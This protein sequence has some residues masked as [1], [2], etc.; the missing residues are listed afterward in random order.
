MLFLGNVYRDSFY[1]SVPADIVVPDKVIEGFVG[2]WLLSSLLAVSCVTV[3]FCA[4]MQIVQDKVTGAIGD[5]SVTPYK[6]SYLALS[7]YLATAA[8]TAAICY[9]A[10]GAGF[11]YLACVGWYI[12]A[13]DALF[14]VLDVFLLS[15]FGTA[16]SS[17][18]CF[19]IKTQGG[20]TA[21]SVVVS[22][23]YGF[24]SGAYM[25]ISQFANGI[26]IFVSLLPGTYG[27]GLFRNHFMGGV[28]AE[29][30][31]YFPPEV[32]DGIRTSFDCNM[33]FFGHKVEVGTMFLILGVTV[34]V[35]IGVYVLL[36]FLKKRAKN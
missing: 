4:N 27:T 3:A 30:G 6:K 5:F 22:S 15:L 14:I 21:V 8:V 29:I 1:S 9:V 7:Y 34:A 23:V 33:F 13:G 12:S 32:V 28:L 31:N 11:I 17:V 26:Q 20:S 24:I 19:F 16:L 25:P 18:I 2:G 35:L 36:H 10:L